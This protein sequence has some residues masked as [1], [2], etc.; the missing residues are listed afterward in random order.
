MRQENN[1]S[2]DKI[3]NVITCFLLSLLSILLTSCFQQSTQKKQLTVELIYGNSD[4][5]EKKISNI[6]WLFDESGFTYHELNPSDNQS[7]IWFYDL[8]SGEKSI[9]LEDGKIKDLIKLNP[10][11]LLDINNYILS[12]TRKE[13]LLQSDMDLFLYSIE[14]HQIKR[15]TQDSAKESAPQFSP[16]GIKVAFLKYD[17]IHFIDLEKGSL[18]QLTFQGN[19]H[20]LVGEADWVYAEEFGIDKGFFWSPDSQNIAFFQMDEREVPIFPIVDFI[21]IQNEVTNT[22]Y[23]KTGEKNS[24]VKVGLVSV[25]NRTTKWVDV[26]KNDDYYI[27]RI[28][29]LPDSHSLAIEKLNRAQNVLELFLFDIQTNMLKTVLKEENAKGWIDVYDDLLFIDNDNRFLWTSNRS[30]YK[31]LYLYD[32]YGKQIQQLTD[33]NWEIDNLLGYDKENNIAYF[34]ATEKASWE[35]HLY[36]V[37]LDNTNFQRISEE[38][39]WHVINMSPYC[40]YYI[41]SFS[42]YIKAEKVS[43]YSKNNQLIDI[44]EA[45]EIQILKQSDLMKPEFFTFVSDEGIHLPVFM[46]K[47]PDFNPNKKYP[48][49]MYTYGGPAIQIVCNQWENDARRRNLWHEMIAQQGYIVFGLDNRGTPFRGRDFLQQ[50]YRQWGTIDVEDKIAGVQYLR[51]LPYV[52]D[53]RIGIWGWSHGGY[54]TCMCMVKGENL[55]KTG[56][57]VAPPTD[58]RNY[59][60]I[61]SERYMDSP[62][63]NPEGYKNSSVLN[64]VEN[65]HGNL[66]LIHGTADDNVHI[67]NTMQL[68]STLENNRIPFDI[69]I[70]PQKKHHLDVENTKV[71]LFNLMTSY[72]KNNL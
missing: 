61:Y 68:I 25:T 62:N 31:H 23:P 50:I 42:T 38:E 55:F 17:N 8:K 56:I 71:H 65:L 32:I 48:V 2:M 63:D 58:W 47:P 43:L 52:D 35:R 11:E 29:W 5:W 45:N 28:K 26:G 60:T 1:P 46:I 41:D 12:P 72:I 16:D 7:R 30:G 9:L 40:N 14:K 57:A 34:R 51:K 59:D 39:G 21:P 66:L 27:P 24:I 64:F 44:I 13:L 33:G 69:M 70:Y 6:Q 67:S 36:Q 22:R 53:K 20:F 37:E 3:R 54:M 15:I 19:K 49:L 10:D 4:L 18:S